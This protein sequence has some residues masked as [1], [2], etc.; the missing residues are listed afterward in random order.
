[1]QI[2]RGHR[3]CRSRGRQLCG[4]CRCRHRAWN[5]GRLRLGAGRYRRGSF[6]TGRWTWSIRLISRSDVGD[7][8]R[9]CPAL[10]RLDVE[11]IG[12]RLGP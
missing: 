11:P 2:R 12:R 7:P 4:C 3:S 1:M 10:G 9:G 8:R 6:T 5:S